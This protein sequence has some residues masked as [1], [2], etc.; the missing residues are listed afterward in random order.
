MVNVDMV[1]D[2]PRVRGGCSESVARVPTPLATV[3]AQSLLEVEEVRAGAVAKNG[4]EAPDKRATEEVLRPR[5]KVKVSNRH[6][7]RHAWR[8]GFQVPCMTDL[9]LCDLEA[10]LEARWSTL[11][12]GTR[13][14]ADGTT[15]TE[16]ARGGVNS[17]ASG[18]P[19]LFTV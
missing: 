15:S 10:P 1:R 16:Y 19:L 17:P 7:S 2:I 6:K 14:W 5:K 13:V 4:V 12:Q 8:R 3:A 9:P 18:R 11:K